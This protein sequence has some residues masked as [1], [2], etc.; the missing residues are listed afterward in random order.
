MHIL[1][2]AIFV[3]KLNYVCNL[4]LHKDTSRDNWIVA[5]LRIRIRVFWSDPDIVMNSD[6]DFRSDLDPV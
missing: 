1:H 2:Y 3:K 4:Y 5:G 6:P